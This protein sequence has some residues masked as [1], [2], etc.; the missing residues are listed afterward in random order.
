MRSRLRHPLAAACHRPAGHCSSLFALALAAV[1]AR[2]VG[3]S[4]RYSY[5]SGASRRRR[6]MN[7]AGPTTYACPSSS[8]C[9]PVRSRQPCRHDAKRFHT[10]RHRAATLPGALVYFIV[11]IRS[12]SNVYD[13]TT[14][15]AGQIFES[16]NLG[17]CSGSHFVDYMI[18]SG[19][20]SYPYRAYYDSG[21]WRIVVAG[22]PDAGVG[23]DN[24]PTVTFAQI[25]SIQPR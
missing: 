2:S 14:N 9:R 21:A 11:G 15:F 8:T 25:C 6:E 23:G 13:A 12:N 4:T 3:E 1:S 24:V 17:S 16:I 19:S 5:T 10:K 20:Y 7:F 18:Y 22:N